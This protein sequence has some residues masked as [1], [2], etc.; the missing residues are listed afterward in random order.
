[1]EYVLPECLPSG[2]SY[3]LKKGSVEFTLVR[4]HSILRAETI[5]EYI[6]KHLW[7][8]RRGSRKALK[9]FPVSFSMLLEAQEVSLQD[10]VRTIRPVEVWGKQKAPR[11]PKEPSLF[12]K[13]QSSHG[14]EWFISKNVRRVKLLK[15]YY[16][17]LWALMM[18]IRK[19]SLEFYTCQF[20]A[21]TFWEHKKGTEWLLQKN[22]CFCPFY[23]VPSIA[24]VG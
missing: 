13:S 6:L 7:S 19:K 11:I 12:L 4:L 15:Y 3:F 22:R 2:S 16:F 20:G 18:L 24:I 21:D 10:F 23:Q 14:I 1:M 5:L 17:V 9:V 8:W